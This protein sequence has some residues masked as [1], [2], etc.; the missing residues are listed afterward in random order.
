MSTGYGSLRYYLDSSLFNEPM[1]THRTHYVGLTFKEVNVIIRSPVYLFS[2]FEINRSLW[3]I[4]CDYSQSTTV[5]YQCSN[6]IFNVCLFHSS[7]YH[8]TPYYLN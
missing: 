6:L 8:I 5:I 1:K 3:V 7:V 4:S 2:I